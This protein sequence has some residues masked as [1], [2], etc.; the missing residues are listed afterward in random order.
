MLFF[1]LPQT[2]RF[3]FFAMEQSDQSAKKPRLEPSPSIRVKKEDAV[4]EGTAGEGGGGGGGAVV[5]AAAEVTG[6]RVEGAIKMD[7][8][9]LHCPL[10]SR[11]LK[12]PV[13]QVE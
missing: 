6:P 4:H 10:C 13:F 1:F 11:P 7:M 3:L 9:L 5:L 2:E 12:P 8:N